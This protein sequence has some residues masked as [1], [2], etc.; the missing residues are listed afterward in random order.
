MAQ[1]GKLARCIEHTVVEPNSTKR[2]AMRAARETLKYGFRGVC[3]L[4]AYVALARDLIKNRARV[5]SVAGFPFGT[6]SIEAKALEAEQA[7]ENGASDVDFVM[8]R[9]MLKSGNYEYI[10]EEIEAVKKAT[11]NSTLKVIIET[12]DL[13]E[14]EI[15]IACELIVKAKADYVKTASGYRGSTKLEDVRFIRRQFPHLQIKASGGIRTYEQ[16]VAFLENGANLIGTSRGVEII[17][18]ALKP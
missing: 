11:G 14:K 12:P 7:I 3:V 9:G 10:K 5:I 8:N 17:K 18:S 13:T 16:A 2:D 1:E 4:P 6:Q 15:K